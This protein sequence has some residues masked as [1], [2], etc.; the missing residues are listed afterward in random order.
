M[1][2]C[3]EFYEK[4]KNNPNWCQKC[5]TSVFR[6]NRYIELTEQYP[7]LS[8]FTERAL[9]PL[10]EKSVPHGEL[11]NIV[12]QIKRELEQGN[13][14]NE[15]SIKALLNPTTTGNLACPRGFIG[16]E[17]GSCWYNRN[18]KAEFCPWNP[19]SHVTQN[20]SMM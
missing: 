20:V 7:F 2:R 19:C 3:K 1:T 18:D 4:W 16:M 12:Q 5:P 13:K 14:L 11:E 9:R 8:Q 15:E 6:I 17:I 10:I